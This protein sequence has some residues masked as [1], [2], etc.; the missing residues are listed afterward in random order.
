M[1]IK[2]DFIR[3]ATAKP[4]V[5]V[6]DC[7]SNASQVLELIHQAVAKKVSLLLFPELTLTSVSCGDLISDETLLNQAEQSLIDIL[8]STEECPIIFILGL[9]IRLYNHILNVAVICY[10]GKILQV[11]PK[12]DNA[13]TQL[14]QGKE[15]SSWFVDHKLC[16]QE[17]EITTNDIL[18]TEDFSF[19]VHFWDKGTFNNF[20]IGH[21]DID[22]FLSDTPDKVGTYTELKNIAIGL[23]VKHGNAFAYNSPGFGES[24]TDLVYSGAA[25]I[26]ESG[27]II[28]EASRFSMESSI[29]YADID[30]ATIHAK[31]LQKQKVVNN[32]SVELIDFKSIEIDKPNRILNAHPFLSK[33]KE[34]DYNDAF[35][36]Q[37]ASLAQRMLHIHTEKVVIGI[38]GGLDSTLALLSCV[39]TFDALNMPRKNILG[40]TMPGFGTSNRTYNNAQVMMKKLGITTKEISIKE[41]CIQHFKDIKH[42]GS[43]QDIT[44]EN[45]QARERT[46]ILM[47][48]A[49]MENALVIGTGDLSE[50]ALGWATYNGDHMSMYDMNASIPKTLVQDLVL[51]AAEQEADAEL[52]QAL[53]DVV[54]T[55]ISPELKPTDNKGLIN[56]KTEDLV[57]PYELHDFFLFNMMK[58]RFSPTRIYNRAI[59]A[60][61]GKYEQE[62]IRHWLK[63]F[64]RRFFMQQ[65]KRSCSPDGPDVTGIS[66]S[67]RGAW[68]MASDASSKIWLNE[69]EKL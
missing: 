23:S 22:L 8:K 26:A 9:P 49:N 1:R 12:M 6:A 42:D 44:Y 59:L 25:F 28:N 15:N 47:D 14:L 51:W 38:S 54:A 30:I 43:T 52:K 33:A 56:Q 13:A 62:V 64:Y 58:Y 68:S 53:L 3:I 50:L 2:R 24:T 10:K 45:S 35:Q 16:N 61:E 18:Q 36:I 55:P 65:F 27:E 4:K 63:Q 69:I 31:S 60:F 5:S 11:I 17:V 57:G 48:I 66:L 39:R 29:T 46:Q 37:V 34:M 40:I 21:A 19:T 67:P 41:A 20:L 32:F 7:F